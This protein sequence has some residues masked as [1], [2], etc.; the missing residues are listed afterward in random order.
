[1]CLRGCRTQDEL[2]GGV[3]LASVWNGGVGHGGGKS[4]CY[5]TQNPVGTRDPFDRRSLPLSKDWFVPR[6]ELPDDIFFTA[7]GLTFL[8]RWDERSVPNYYI[9][10]PDWMPVLLLLL[11]PSL[12]LWSRWRG[13]C[14]NG[15]C[16]TCGYN[17]LG[18]TSGVCPEC[19]TACTTAENAPQT[20]PQGE[21]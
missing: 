9:V 20:V 16:R 19:G 1:L 21:K 12:W 10:I 3:R 17:L 7:L 18:N 2:S 13:R 15:S 8:A 4:F 6:R 11:L 14:K 5:V